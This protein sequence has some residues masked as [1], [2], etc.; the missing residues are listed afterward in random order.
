MFVTILYPCILRKSIESLLNK[1]EEEKKEAC[2]IVQNLQIRRIVCPFRQGGIAVLSAAKG[3][4][5]PAGK[6]P[7]R[8][9]FIPGTILVVTQQRKSPAGKLNPDLMAAACVEQN[10]NNGGGGF[11]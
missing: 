1:Y 3:E 7:G 11:G 8:G 5:D 2:K 4:G 10:T 6:E 9:V